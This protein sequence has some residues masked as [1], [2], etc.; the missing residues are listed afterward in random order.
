MKERDT[1]RPFECCNTCKTIT[2]IQVTMLDNTRNFAKTKNFTNDKKKLLK[3]KSKKLHTI[4]FQESQTWKEPDKLWNIT[5]CKNLQEFESEE[6]IS[7]LEWKQNEKNYDI[8]NFFAC[9]TR[10][11]K[12]LP[13]ISK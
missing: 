5:C 13:N 1:L 9:V 10:K 7:L 2:I 3:Q 11:W 6:N 12:E 8:D 4:N